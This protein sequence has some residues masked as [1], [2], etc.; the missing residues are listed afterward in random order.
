MRLII[1]CV[2][3]SFLAIV[4]QLCYWIWRAITSAWISKE[5][6]GMVEGGTKDLVNAKQNYWPISYCIYTTTQIAPAVST[7]PTSSKNNATPQNHVFIIYCWH[8]SPHAVRF[9]PFMRKCQICTFVK[10]V[11][12]CLKVFVVYI[13]H[14]LYEG[15][16]STKELEGSKK[17]NSSQS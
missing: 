12:L 7:N 3:P 4:H 17:L 8:V 13:N 15:E 6:L 14:L 5:V 16:V 10:G 1:D 2:V 11:V 9:S